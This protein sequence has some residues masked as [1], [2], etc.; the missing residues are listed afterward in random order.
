[1]LLI[2]ATLP[3]RRDEPLPSP[4]SVELDPDSEGAPPSG[5]TVGASV[6]SVYHIVC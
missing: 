2:P 3:K 5:A 1:M 6:G 4:G